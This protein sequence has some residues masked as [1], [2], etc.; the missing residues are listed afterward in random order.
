MIIKKVLIVDD[1]AFMRGMLKRLIDKSDELE[2]IGTAVDGRDGIE[3][4]M[5]LKPDVI[6]MDVEMP[7]MTG[8]D[9]LKGIMKVCPTPVVMISTLTEEGARVTLEALEAG[10][11]D[12]LPKAL[13]DS[14]RNVFRS[15]KMLHEKLLAAASARVD[16]LSR[17]PLLGV[18]NKFVSTEKVVNKF[19]ADLVVIGSSTG[20]PKALHEVVKGL[21]SNL[22]VPIVIA[23]H[24]PAE[25]TNALANRLN[26]TC[27][28]SVKQLKDGEILKSGIVYISPGG[29]HTRV[30]SDA[31]AI[32]F[33]VSSDMGE[34]AYKPSVDILGE[35]VHET[36]GKRVLAVMLTGMGNDGAKAFC[37]MKESGAHIIA[38]DEATCVVYG[39]P[40]S[41][42][43][44]GG[45]TEV[46]PI[47]SIASRIAGL[48]S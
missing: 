30:Q 17:K 24:M 7:V 34:S 45:A 46:L 15:A 38:Q 16:P 19:K 43:E 41:V 22:C 9:A 8:L 37:S 12:F 14:D 36:M 13:K 23:Q 47:T 5:Q 48:L 31:G 28:I 25:F 44:L 39:M 11:V 20:G 4:A 21:P 29:K 2:V 1:S 26:E 40:R 42:V 3:K 33:R 27:G 35:S 6:T 10:A 18:E 32:T